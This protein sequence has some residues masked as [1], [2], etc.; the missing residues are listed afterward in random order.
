ME[1]TS[2]FA[3]IFVFLFSIRTVLFIVGDF[4]FCFLLKTFRLG[5]IYDTLAC[6]YKVKEKGLL[7]GKEKAQRN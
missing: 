4:R 3:F 1:F 6:G 5:K 2:S 7:R